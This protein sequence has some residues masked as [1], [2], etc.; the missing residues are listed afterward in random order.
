MGCLHEEATKMI[1]VHQKAPVLADLQ[2]LKWICG[3][4]HNNVFRS[5]YYSSCVL[6]LC[7]YGWKTLTPR[8]SSKKSIY[9]VQKRIW[10]V[11][12]HHLP[13]QY[14][15]IQGERVQDLQSLQLFNIMGC[16]IV[17]IDWITSR[18]KSPK[19]VAHVLHTK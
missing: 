19:S 16:S 13:Q 12:D 14:F 2:G 4:P 6:L 18:S 11:T 15:Y 17:L 7:I 3:Q 9:L 8:T 10:Q 1:Q 5:R